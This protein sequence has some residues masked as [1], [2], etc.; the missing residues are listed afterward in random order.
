MRCPAGLYQTCQ[1]AALSDSRSIAD[2]DHGH[3]I[4]LDLFHHSHM[5]NK[6]ETKYYLQAKLHTS[7]PELY[8]SMYHCFY[9]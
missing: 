1:M 9:K 3:K 4:K 2:P 6:S 5:I 7:L 8:W